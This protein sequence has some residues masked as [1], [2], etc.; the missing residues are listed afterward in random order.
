MAENKQ[1]NISEALLTYGASDLSIDILKHC[2]L[3]DLLELSVD[4]KQA[5]VAFRASWALEHI[6][7]KHTELFKGIIP[8]LLSNYTFTDN[9]SSLRSYTKLWM[10]LLSEKNTAYNITPE[11]EEQLLEKTFAIIED[12]DCPVAVLVNAY[13]ILMYLVPNHPWVA[14]ELRLQLE[15]SLE[16]EASAA[17]ISR[18]KRLFKK[19]SR[20]KNID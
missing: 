8:T 10:W 5:R 7:L 17:L 1:H 13:D 19:L 16:K 15:L 14:Q 12:S 18:A 4:P 11:Q 2:S 9:W 20:V 3:Q 6:L